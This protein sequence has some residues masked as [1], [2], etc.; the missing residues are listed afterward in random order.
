VQCDLHEWINVHEQ[1]RAYN[2]FCINRHVPTILLFTAYTFV[3]TDLSV[4]CDLPEWVN[5]HEQVRAYNLVMQI[6]IV[7]GTDSDY[8]IGLQSP[9]PPFNVSSQFP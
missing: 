9:S 8:L 5:L 1:V 6:Q 3:G 2:P 7:E 4:L